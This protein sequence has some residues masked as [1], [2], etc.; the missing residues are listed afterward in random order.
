[1][2]TNLFLYYIDYGLKY[3][4][5][6]VVRHIEF[7][8]KKEFF[9]KNFLRN[10]L[11]KSPYSVRIREN[12]EQKNSEYGQILRSEILGFLRICENLRKKSLTL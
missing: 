12:T 1:M 6:Q 4:C 11:C 2:N 10:K 3:I 8:E 7:M 9:V 5:W